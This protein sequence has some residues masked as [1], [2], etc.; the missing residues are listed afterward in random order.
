[1][2]IQPISHSNNIPLTVHQ[3]NPHPQFSGLR[4]LGDQTKG[5][6]QVQVDSICCSSLVPQ[7]HHCILE[8]H[9]ISQAR[10]A[11]GEATLA[12]S[13]HLPAFHILPHKLLEDG[14]LQTIGEMPKSGSCLCPPPSSLHQAPPLLPFASVWP[15]TLDRN[16]FSPKKCQ[17][18]KTIPK[19]KSLQRNF[20]FQKP[21]GE[22]KKKKDTRHAVV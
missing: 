8:G 1:M 5:L 4:V 21:C 12:A 3:S 6:A 10:F 2:D 7:C 14:L 17:F 9:Q 15:G 13:N 18:I 22:G 16:A 19:K 11:I 20:S